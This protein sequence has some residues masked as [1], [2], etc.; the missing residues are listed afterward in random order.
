MDTKDTDRWLENR[1]EPMEE[2]AAEK[3]NLA[4]PWQE[5]EEEDIYPVQQIAAAE[6]IS[7]KEVKD[8][9]RELNPDC[10]SLDSR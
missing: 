5:E 6:P 1:P 7:E 8:A 10:N 9:V 2:P 4:S 3:G